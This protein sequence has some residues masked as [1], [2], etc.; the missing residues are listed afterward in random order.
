MSTAASRG[1]VVL[2]LSALALAI[3]IA[4]GTRPAGEAPSPS[5]DNDGRALLAEAPIAAAHAALAEAE[6]RH[7]RRFAEAVD[8]EAAALARRERLRA[9]IA[10]GDDG[11]VQAA[12]LD[13]FTRDVV[14]RTRK[15][16]AETTRCASCHYKPS[17]GGAGGLVDDYVGGMNPPSLAGAA[18]LERLASEMTAE[19]KKQR[20]AGRPLT[21][22]GID[23]GTASAP[24]GV[25]ADLVVRP[26]GRTGRWATLD[27]AIQ[28]MADVALA[29]EFADDERIALRAFV[30]S[31]P[32]PTVEPPD[33]ARL[34]D[35][36]DRFRRGRTAFAEAGCAAC[37]VPSLTLAD[38]TAVA[39]FTDLKRHD[40]GEALARGAGGA[41]PGS[42]NARNDQQR[43]WLTAPLWGVGG[44]APWLHDGRALAS[45]DAAILLH[46]GEAEAARKAYAAFPPARQG[47]IKV[48]LLSHVP[49]PKIQVAGR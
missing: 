19:L 16:L 34:T 22:Q 25:D 7:E 39:A 30:A 41:T 11:A 13:L 35:L 32:P 38:G 46:G 49:A 43:M 26:F 40:M 5:G 20:A 47:D 3:G 44:T 17:S 4:F 15:A 45:L 29:V 37:H 18:L 23:F 8:P 33:A 24:R 12:G 27:H 9:A 31:L 21:V 48:F 42:A 10:A 1:S 6:A 36:F 2:S 14:P 28:E